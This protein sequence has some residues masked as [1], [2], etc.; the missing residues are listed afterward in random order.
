MEEEPKFVDRNKREKTT[1][2]T[3]T[4]L[5]DFVCLVNYFAGNIK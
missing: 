4:I 5:T 3:I 2:V 1:T